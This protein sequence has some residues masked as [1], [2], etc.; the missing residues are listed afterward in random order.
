MKKNTQFL[1]IALLS[2]CASSY[3]MNDKDKKTKLE[4]QAAGTTSTAAATACTT[5]AQSSKTPT[6]SGLLMMV[7][8]TLA[9]IQFPEAMPVSKFE[10]TSL[11]DKSKAA[12]S[13][14]HDHNEFT[15]TYIKDVDTLVTYLAAILPEAKSLF[16]RSSR[17]IAE[18]STVPSAVTWVERMKEMGTRLQS[19][20]K[21]QALGLMQLVGADNDK[22]AQAIA[23]QAKMFK[24]EQEKRD[25]E[26]R[27]LIESLAKQQKEMQD[28]MVQFLAVV[29]GTNSTASK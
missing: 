1:L 23:D 7:E 19:I 3:S 10:V 29:K 2:V 9:P 28:S 18:A 27:A 11:I 12:L 17:F 15:R 8:M 24:E 5:V 22:Q 25:K 26:H 13:D 21:T 20:Q 16:N 6:I 14:L 4:P